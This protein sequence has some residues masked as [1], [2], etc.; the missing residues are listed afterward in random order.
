MRPIA[1]AIPLLAIGLLVAACGGGV[2]PLATAPPADATQVVRQV[3]TPLA[4]NIDGL[5]PELAALYR[6]AEANRALVSRLPCYCGC[7]ASQGHRSLQDCFLIP[8]GGY[9]AHAATCGICEREAVEARRL[10]GEGQ[11]T[12]AIRAFIDA[13]FGRFGAPTNTP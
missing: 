5:K 13:N 8:T 12:S 9:D 4:V 11:D 7:G 6:W 2:K 3:P 10:Q 1:V